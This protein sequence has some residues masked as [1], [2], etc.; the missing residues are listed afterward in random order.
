[1][2]KVI[3]PSLISDHSLMLFTH[4]TPPLPQTRSKAVQP[5]ILPAEGVLYLT[6]Y[7]VIFI[8]FPLNSDDE[9]TIIYR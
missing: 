9:N 3:T 5:Q 8:G 7:R 6:N 1:M 2:P 4:L